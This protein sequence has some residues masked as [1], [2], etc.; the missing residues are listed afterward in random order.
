MREEVRSAVAPALALL[1]PSI[2]P[3]NRNADESEFSRWDWGE[4]M[5]RR[6]P[7]GFTL[8]TGN[9]R[10]MWELWHFGNRGIK[11]GPYK[12]ITSSLLET[13][14]YIHVYMSGLN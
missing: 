11:V 8:P 7:R 14:S 2:A 1:Q 10:Q 12:Y 13:V 9:V 6:V 3:N 5:R 4:K